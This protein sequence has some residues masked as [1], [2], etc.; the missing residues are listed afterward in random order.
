MP[1]SAFLRKKWTVFFFT[2]VAVIVIDQ[3]TKAVI[4][5]RLYPNDLIEVVPG[6][7]NI[8]YYRNTGAAFGIFRGVSAIKTLFLI[9]VTGAA[10]IFIA[11]MIR[12]CE[13]LFTTLTLSLI[14]GGAV[15]NLIDRLVSGSVL[16]F[17]DFYA[18]SYHWPAFNVADSAITTGVVSTIL[19]FSL[20]KPKRPA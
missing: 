4:M 11:F 8:V 1:E 2:A 15:G 13:D 20:K 18:G 7:F 12:R 10:L 9:T 17:L 16:D 5:S 14:A 19:I 6:L 3:I